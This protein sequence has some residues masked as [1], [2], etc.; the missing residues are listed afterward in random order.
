M[1]LSPLLLVLKTKAIGF[2]TN[3]SFALVRNDVLKVQMESSLVEQKV[4]SPLCCSHAKLR[5]TVGKRKRD[6]SLGLKLTA[7]Q[8]KIGRNLQRPQI[9]VQSWQLF[10]IVV[11]RMVMSKIIAMMITSDFDGWGGSHAGSVNTGMEI[12]EKLSGGSPPRPSAQAHCFAALPLPQ[13]FRRAL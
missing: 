3:G 9:P 2:A 10:L 6:F 5:T 8:R 12:E 7:K 11:S 1:F 13:V 4:F